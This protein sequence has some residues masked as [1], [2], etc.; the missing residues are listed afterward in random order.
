LS[1]AFSS[2]L[3]AAVLVRSGVSAVFTL[4]AAAMCGV[5]LIIALFGPRTNRI[6]LE[7]LAR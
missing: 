4:L 5:A 3:I 7:Q 2:V 1:A 6:A